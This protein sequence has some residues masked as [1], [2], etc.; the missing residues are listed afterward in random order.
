[1][2]QQTNTLAVVSAVL[3]LLGFFGILPFVG[4]IGAIICGHM[5]RGQIA[6]DPDQSGAGAAMLGLITGYG[7]ILLSCLAIGFAIL[8]FGG[9]TALLAFLGLASAAAG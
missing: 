7:A 4:S 6:Q 3:G 8:W 9:I 5:A 1:M 2:S